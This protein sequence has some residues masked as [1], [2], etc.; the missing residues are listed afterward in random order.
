MEHK[1]AVLVGLEQ[2]RDYDGRGN[3]L[4]YSINEVDYTTDQ[5]I[6]EVKNDTEVGRDFSKMVY[7][8]IL[9]F[10]GKFNPTH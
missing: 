4:I 7:N 3:G 1:N 2:M 5:M 10:M 6:E 9:S 8:M